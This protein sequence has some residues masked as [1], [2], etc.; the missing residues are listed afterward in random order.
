MSVL[1]LLQFRYIRLFHLWVVVGSFSFRYCWIYTP[2][3]TSLRFTV[4]VSENSSITLH[5]LHPTLYF[6]THM[7]IK[8]SSICIASK[9]WRRCLD[10]CIHFSSSQNAYSIPQSGVETPVTLWITVVCSADPFCNLRCSS[11]KT[12]YRQYEHSIVGSSAQWTYARKRNFEHLRIEQPSTSLQLAHGWISIKLC[13]LKV[14]WRLHL[15]VY[16]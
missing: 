6:P 1:P 12:H 15:S 14:W 11:A 16:L 4:L 10:M 2:I 5:V 7:Q 9:R 3:P 8:R 13:E